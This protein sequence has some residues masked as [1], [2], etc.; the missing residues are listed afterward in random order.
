MK[1]FNVPFIFSVFALSF[2]VISPTKSQDIWLEGWQASPVS[3][4][5]PG[6]E[7]LVFIPGDQGNWLVDDTVSAFL[8]DGCGPDQNKAEI[9]LD[10]ENKIL[11]LTSADSPGDCAENIWVLIGHQNAPLSI[12]INTGTRISF[13][14]MGALENPFWNGSFPTVTPPP[15]SNVH[16][17]LED[18][19]G[20]VL[21][22]ILQRALNYIAHT[23]TFFQ[24]DNF[25][26]LP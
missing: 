12:P 18:N 2:L 6:G 4:F 22:Y 20:N 9:F 19:R 3:S 26:W 7:N 8:D 5:T 16:L 1:K 13:M 17:Y 14:E 15:G 21:V 24:R 25:S 10:R 23:E 11:R